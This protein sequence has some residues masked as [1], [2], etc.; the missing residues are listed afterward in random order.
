MAQTADHGA[1]VANGDV[2]N[3]PQRRLDERVD[4]PDPLIELELAMTGHGLDGDR[5]LV[6]GDPL[7][8]FDMLNV[9]QQ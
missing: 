7:Q 1:A 3:M 4:L 9:D 6:E 2:G 5:M 8:T